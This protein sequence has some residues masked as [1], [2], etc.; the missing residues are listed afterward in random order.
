MALLIHLV[1]AFSSLFVATLLYIRPTRWLLLT[2]YALITGT[3]VSGSYLV[4]TAP[5]HLIEAC[6]MG[7][8]YLCVV[9]VGTVFARQRLL[10]LR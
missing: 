9:G 6:V 7:L 2:S 1:I 10:S 5:S 8:S 4:V 3:L